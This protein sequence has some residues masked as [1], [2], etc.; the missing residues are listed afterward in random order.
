MSPLYP[1]LAVCL[2]LCLRDQCRLLHSFPWSS[3]S[4]NA[5]NYIQTCNTLTY[6]C[7][8]KFQQCIAW[9]RSSATSAMCER[10]MGIVCLEWVSNPHFC[11]SGPVCKPLHHICFPDV[12]TMPTS[13]CICGCLPQR[14]VQSIIHTYNLHPPYVALHCTGH[15]L[16]QL[17]TFTG[18]STH[19]FTRHKSFHLIIPFM[20]LVS[21]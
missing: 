15:S 12:T 1:P 11:H 17:F 14:S 4:F 7:T 9:L 6:T 10:T 19:L 2:A 8:D 18:I 20:S 5:H 21:L 3:K 16:T 13:T